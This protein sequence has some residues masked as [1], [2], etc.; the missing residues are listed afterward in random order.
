MAIVNASSF[1]TIGPS[2]LSVANMRLPTNKTITDDKTT[3][4]LKG[5]LLAHTNA[6]TREMEQL[7]PKLRAAIESGN[8]PEAR[9]TIEALASALGS[10]MYTL[11]YFSDRTG[12]SLYSEAE[13][14]KVSESIEKSYCDDDVRKKMPRKS[15]LY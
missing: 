10:A 3:A 8:L 9:I 12:T 6:E 5:Y 2:A 1:W 13:I 15:D 7:V 11:E 14:T 4:S